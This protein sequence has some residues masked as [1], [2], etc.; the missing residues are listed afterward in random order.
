M[1]DV[2]A[3]RLTLGEYVKF[4]PPSLTHLHLHHHRES[5]P[6]VQSIPWQ[7]FA[8]CPGLSHFCLSGPI[9]SRFLTDRDF[10]S[11]VTDPL[12]ALLSNIAMF[13]VY[14]DYPPSMGT[15]SDIDSIA[16]NLETLSAA[17]DRL[18]VISQAGRDYHGQIANL[19]CFLK[20]RDFKSHWGDG[21]AKD[22]WEFADIG[23]LKQRVDGTGK[24]SW[25]SEMVN[26]NAIHSMYDVQVV[27]VYWASDEIVESR[28]MYFVCMQ[29]R[30]KFGPLYQLYSQGVLAIAIALELLKGWRTTT[31]SRASDQGGE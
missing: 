10:I 3:Q 31:P 23:L 30:L 24:P 9:A 22:I 20:Y 1:L 4:V 27:E 28:M 15:Q 25:S 21:G 14:V 8:A 11:L 19:H 13:V 12:A 6:N 17:S 2:R 7:L 26:R 18:V 5:R 29:A 16:S